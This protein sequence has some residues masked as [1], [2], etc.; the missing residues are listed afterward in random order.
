VTL[1]LVPL[2]ASFEALSVVWDKIRKMEISDKEIERMVMSRGK[3]IRKLEKAEY[4]KDRPP[5]LKEAPETLY[6]SCDGT[7]CH[8]AEEGKKKI[9]GRLGMVFT[10]KRA[11]VSKGRF[12]LLEKRYCA[13]FFGKDDFADQLEQE[14]LRFRVEEA[15]QVIFAA[16]GEQALWEIKKDRFPKA[17]GILDWNHLSRRLTEALLVIESSAKRDKSGDVIR[18]LLW[19]S[20]VDAAIRKLGRIHAEEAQ[21][22]NPSERQKKRLE[23]L[24]EYVTYLENNRPWIINYAEAQAKGLYIGSSVMESA[25][26][27]LLANRLKKKKSRQ[28]LREGADSV[29]RI[30]T[31]IENGDWQGTWEK[32]CQVSRN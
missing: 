23:R 24:Q 25:M 20:E 11:E 21:K 8:S 29:A 30:V 14:A 18:E 4:E 7:F 17:L 3:Q 5:L 9:E 27:H 22:Q 15:K 1:E 12:K 32:I 10:N 2:T 26:N 19:E 6:I 13:S 31:L 16:D 28:W